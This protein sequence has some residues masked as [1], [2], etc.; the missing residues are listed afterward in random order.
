MLTDAEEEG[1]SP[2]VVFS[3]CLHGGEKLDALLQGHRGFLLLRLQHALVFLVG[4]D[5]RCRQILV[6][7]SSFTGLLDDYRRRR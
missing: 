2:G 7:C 1:S 6:D 5:R 4:L 3:Q